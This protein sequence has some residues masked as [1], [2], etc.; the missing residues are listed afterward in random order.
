MVHNKQLGIQRKH[1]IFQE[2]MYEVA[3]ITVIEFEQ[4]VLVYTVYDEH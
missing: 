2:Y 3:C 4:L 1:H